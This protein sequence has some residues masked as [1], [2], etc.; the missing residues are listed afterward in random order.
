MGM[1]TG[2][3]LGSTPVA[4][5][6]NWILES[7]SGGQGDLRD[8]TFGGETTTSTAMRTRIN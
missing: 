6:A 8:I 1:F 5:V 2:S 4:G 7:A 3:V